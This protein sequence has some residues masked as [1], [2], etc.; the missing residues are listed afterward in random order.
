MKL[1][2]VYCLLVFSCLL[3]SSQILCLTR[4]GNLNFRS[5][6]MQLSM[7]TLLQKPKAS[8]SLDSSSFVS[9]G[10]IPVIKPHLALDIFNPRD[11]KP[12]PKWLNLKFNDKINKLRKLYLPQRLLT[13]KEEKVAA[14]FIQIGRKLKSSK[15][16]LESKL[17]RK[18][19]SLEWSDATGISETQ[20]QLYLSLAQKAENRLI[21][22]NM[23]L[24]DYLVKTIKTRFSICNEL[25]TFDLVIEAYR[26]LAQAVQIFDGRARF[27]SIASVMIYSSILRGISTMKPGYILNHN[28]NMKLHSVK[29]A[30]IQLQ[31]KLRRP[32]QKAEIASYLKITMSTLA[33]Y[34]RLNN[35]KL[36]SNTYIDRDDPEEVRLRSVFEL[37][38]VTKKVKHDDFIGVSPRALSEFYQ[39]LNSMSLSPYAYRIL[40]YKFGLFNGKPM[41][42]EKVGKLMDYSS[43]KIRIDITNLID[44]LR[45]SNRFNTLLLTED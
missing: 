11:K 19:T 41:T 29:N 45:E 5:R 25:S 10:V 4:S 2:N 13:D 31:R 35:L 8:A 43:E 16:K 24:V 23:R 9:N 1:Q 34:E 37:A 3:L 40:Q 42:Y 20:L 14:K 30:K 38:A 7:S 33:K 15:V 36:T 27:S 32:P 39:E 18:L 12:S 21:L 26:G 22:H 28:C 44:T 17:K 6:G